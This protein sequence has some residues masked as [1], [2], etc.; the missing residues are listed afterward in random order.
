[1][2]LFNR[3]GAALAL[4][5]ASLMVCAVPASATTIIT[6]TS[7]QET[8][9]AAGTV[10]VTTNYTNSTTTASDV[11]G[12]S[13]TV[14]ATIYSGNQFYRACYWLDAVKAT[15]T[16]G[17]VTLNVNGSDVTNSAR[18]TQSPARRQTMNTCFVGPRPTDASFIV[19]L[20]GVSEDTNTLTIYA[21]SQ[22]SVEVF[23]FPQ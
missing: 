11:T 16:S 22:M 9:V 8:V 15:A 23:Y 1:M 6:P 19:K 14:P 20:R 10:D 4:V 12:L 2:K 17:T 13:I 21:G 5:A 18:Q 3:I 7:A